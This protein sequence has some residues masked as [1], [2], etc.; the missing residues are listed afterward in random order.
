VS[1]VIRF[2]EGSDLHDLL[3]VSK[4][5]SL[6]RTR[7]IVFVILK[8]FMVCSS[9]GQCIPGKSLLT[10]RNTFSDLVTKGWLPIILEL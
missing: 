6:L 7:N 1:K 8:P 2:R 9:V 4:A 10:P 5:G 3:L